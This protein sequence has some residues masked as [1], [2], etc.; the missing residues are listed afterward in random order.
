MKAYGYTNGNKENEYGYCEITEI[1][2]AASPDQLREMSKFLLL[3]AQEMEDMGSSYDHVHLQ[4]RSE[5]WSE[6]WPDIVVAKS[7]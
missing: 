2:L 4:D 3:A 1:S 5:H 6:A 7:E